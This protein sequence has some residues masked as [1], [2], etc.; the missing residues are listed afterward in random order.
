MYSQSSH[1]ID[2]ENYAKWQYN[3]FTFNPITHKKLKSLKAYNFE[4]E[5]MHVV[6]IATAHGGLLT[7][8]YRLFSYMKNENL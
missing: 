5:R 7:Y 3:C 8:H 2:I 6:S 1:D 4:S